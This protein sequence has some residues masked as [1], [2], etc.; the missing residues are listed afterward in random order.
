ML[1]QLTMDSEVIHVYSRLQDVGFRALIKF[2]KW[3]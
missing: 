3:D 1:L 2:S